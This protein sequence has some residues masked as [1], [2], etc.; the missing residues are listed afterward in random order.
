[1]GAHDPGPRR[2]QK[3]PEQDVQ[4]A[5]LARLRLHPAVAWL[6]RINS[7]AYKTSDGR[8]IRF[9]FPGCPDLLGQ[10][11]DGRIIM[12]EVKSDTG[13]VTDEQRAVIERVVSNK[14]VAGVCRSVEDA[15]AIVNG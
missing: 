4:N 7:G 6:V 15:L 13:R 8:F 9:G 10:M 3:H 5:I 12:L 11:R 2:A 14:G 1:M